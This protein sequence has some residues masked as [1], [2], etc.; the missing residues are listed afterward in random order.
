MDKRVN[1]LICG[2]VTAPFVAAAMEWDFGGDFSHLQLLRMAAT[3][4][5][6]AVYVGITFALATMRRPLPRF[7][8]AWFTV[9][10]PLFFRE[11]L[12]AAFHYEGVGW[13][14]GFVSGGVIGAIA[15]LVAV[16][17]DSLGW[18]GSSGG[19]KPG[20]PEPDVPLTRRTRSTV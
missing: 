19:G 6:W 3:T 16:L 20:I 18:L 8:F 2:I 4:G 12:H 1:I 5:L 15:I 14:W 13:W 10:A 7:F 9:A 11:I 17:F